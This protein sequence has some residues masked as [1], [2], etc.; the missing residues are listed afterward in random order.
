MVLI[1]RQLLGV[2]IMQIVQYQTNSSDPLGQLSRQLRVVTRGPL[3]L[4]TTVDIQY[5]VNLDAQT[6][7]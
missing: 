6:F 4:H 7:I 1:Y 3:P 2:N 5:F